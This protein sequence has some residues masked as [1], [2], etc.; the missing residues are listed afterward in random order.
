MALSIDG[1]VI[2]PAGGFGGSATGSVTLT[3]S[4]A[5]D[6]IVVLIAAE[7]FSSPHQT[8]SSVTATGLT[9]TKRSSVYQDNSSGKYGTTWNTLEVWSAAATGA[10]SSVS[11]T[12][13]MSAA[14]DCGMIQAFGVN[15]DGTL[16]PLWSANASLPNTVISSATSVPSLGSNNTNG[17]ALLFGFVGSAIDTSQTA[18]TGYTLIDSGFNPNGG[19]TMAS[20]AEYQAFASAVSGQTVAF[21]S[22]WQTWLMI[23]DAIEAPRASDT[24]ADGCQ[25]IMM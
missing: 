11:I 23:V 20:G 19:I 25:I 24:L 14:I 1:H 16:L 10:L 7:V 12:V 4:L 9:F 15:Y 8:V 22:S 17:A 21:G 2:T 6:L 13:T 18:G 5:Q 3:T